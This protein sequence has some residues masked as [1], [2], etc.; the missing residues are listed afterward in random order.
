L[1]QLKG[2]CHPSESVPTLEGVPLSN[3]D[4]EGEV[5]E[6]REDIE[7]ERKEE[8]EGETEEESSI[9]QD[10]IDEFEDSE[11]RRWKRGVNGRKYKTFE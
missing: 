9:D 4:K 8:R 2:E 10:E 3:E 6:K 5:L 1:R 7:E 11:K